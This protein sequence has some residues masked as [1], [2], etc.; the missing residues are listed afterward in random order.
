[1]RLACSRR[2]RRI[3]VAGLSL[4]AGL[5]SFSVVLN[6]LAPAPKSLDVGSATLTI[7]ALPYPVRKESQ[8]N[9]YFVTLASWLMTSNMTKIMIMMPEDEFDPQEMLLPRL[10]STFGAERILFGPSI[11]TDEDGVPFIDDWFVKGL[12]SVDSDLVCWINSDIILPRAWFP[13]IEFLYRHFVKFGEQFAVI[14]R[15]CDFELSE[16]EAA[17]VYDDTQLPDFD[18]LASRRKLHTTWGIDFFLISRE[19][20]Q[21]DFD[22]IPPFHMGKYRW[23]PWITGWMK[24]HMPLITL[25][26][27]FCTYHRSHVPKARSASDV[28]CKENFEHAKRHHGYKVPNAKAT[29]YLQGRGMFKNGDKVADFPEWVPDGNAPLE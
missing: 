6:L 12:D 8:R 23:D 22:D 20:M 29:Y 28:K 13:R 18:S 21:I 9:L 1:M 25:G 26:D 27:D 16:E 15:R 4:I 11:E 10:R 2:H 5:S 3:V 17:T 24:E 19:P 14:S 7:V